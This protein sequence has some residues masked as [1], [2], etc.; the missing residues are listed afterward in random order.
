[1]CICGLRVASGE[2]DGAPVVWLRVAVSTLSDSKA[3]KRAH[4]SEKRSKSLARAELGILPLPSS[5]GQA[6]MGRAD[7]DSDSDSDSD[8]NNA[9]R[10]IDGGPRQ[11]R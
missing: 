2:E 8:L 4:S 7:S 11:L 10:Q 1:M 3:E 6:V 5:C 9:Q